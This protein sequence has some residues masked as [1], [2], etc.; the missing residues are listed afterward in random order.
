MYKWS[1]EHLMIRQAVRDFVD[2]EI[3]PKKEELEHGDTPPYDVLRLL[4]STFGMDTMARAGF[5]A[6]IAHE[7]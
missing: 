5:E 6:R 1:D 3:V 7:E 4:F 2:K